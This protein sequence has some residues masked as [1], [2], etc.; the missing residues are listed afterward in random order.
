[1]RPRA[2]LGLKLVLAASII[3]CLLQLS[4]GRGVTVY[5][6]TREYHG[7]GGDRVDITSSADGSVSPGDSLVVN[8][9]TAGIEELDLLP[10]IGPE[11]AQ[12][13]IDY[14]EAYGGFIAVEELAEVKGIGKETYEMLEPYVTV[15]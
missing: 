14:R 2:R 13:I 5:N 3:V 1:M 12:R 4:G 8:I 7:T 11:L 15:D 10:G 9:N 6:I